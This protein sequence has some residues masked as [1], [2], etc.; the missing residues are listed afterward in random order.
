MLWS[1]WLK[2]VRFG[3]RHTMAVDG[4]ANSAMM[5]LLFS[6]TIDIFAFMDIFFTLNCSRRRVFCDC[7]AKASLAWWYSCDDARSIYQGMND[8]WQNVNA[9]QVT[10]ELDLVFVVLWVSLLREPSVPKKGHL[11]GTLADANPNVVLETLI[12]MC[13][14]ISKRI[15]FAKH[16]R[17]QIPCSR[18][19]CTD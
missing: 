11:K 3:C 16:Y 19:S 8:C 4:A 15:K 12:L 14:R 2:L 17:M 13:V 6:S 10:R 5:E 1:F 7:W 9:E 18:H